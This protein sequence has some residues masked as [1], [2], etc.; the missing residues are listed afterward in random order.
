[1]HMHHEWEIGLECMKQAIETKRR[2]SNACEIQR[3]GTA[4]ENLLKAKTAP[5]KMHLTAVTQ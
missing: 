5:K 1:M 2:I 3:A 4:Q